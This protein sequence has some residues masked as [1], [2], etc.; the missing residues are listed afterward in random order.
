MA[1]HLKKYTLA[2]A[3]AFC[4]NLP[5]NLFAGNE[6]RVGQAGATELLI[7]PWARSSGWG[8][9]NVASV[10]G[11][12][13]GFLNIAGAAHVSKTEIS[14]T[15]TQWL[16]GSDVTLSALGIVQKVGG[17]GA[18]GISLT[19]VGFGDIQVTTTDQPEGGLGTYTPQFFNLGL[20]YSKAFSNS[21]YGGLTA[22]VISES[23]ADVKTSGF[24]FDA[25]I[26]YITGFNEAKDNFKFGITLRNVGSPMKFSG[27]GLSFFA[28]PPQGDY[29]LTVEQRTER[30][31]MPSLVNIGITYDWALAAN[32]ML[33]IAGSFTSNSFT[34]DNYG[35]GLEYSFKKLFSLRGGYVFEKKQGDAVESLT[36]SKGLSGGVSFDIPLGKGG[37]TFG[38]DYSYSTTRYFDGTQRIGARLSL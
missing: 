25:G 20:S 37:K 23:I 12:E 30:F 6:D 18:I 32:H 31:E 28:N 14:F 15:H 10:K 27:D 11:A 29:Q 2:V 1:K 22:R 19:S 34:N 5:F 26:Q 4:I 3:V 16:K 8:G 24:A 33:S 13:S 38:I 17:S 9:V 35:A 7:N 36:T 21:I